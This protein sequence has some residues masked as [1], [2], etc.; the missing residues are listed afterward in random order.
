MLW[1]DLILPSP[2]HP[3]PRLAEWPLTSIGCVV[4]YWVFLTCR[5]FLGQHWKPLLLWRTNK[6]LWSKISSVL[7]ELKYS[8]RFSSSWAPVSDPPSGGAWAAYMC[9]IGAL[10]PLWQRADPSERLHL[11]RDS[12]LVLKTAETPCALRP[13]MLS[14][15]ASK[16]NFVSSLVMFFPTLGVA[17]IFCRWLIAQT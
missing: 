3:F 17:C 8:P 15:H 2:P 1:L 13:C 10:A 12:W 6:C 9:T 4:N 16:P 14:G 5:S 7:L 11:R